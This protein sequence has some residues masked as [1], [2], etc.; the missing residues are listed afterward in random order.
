[1]STEQQAH[2]MPNTSFAFVQFVLTKTPC[3]VGTLLTYSRMLFNLKINES[4]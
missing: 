3:T 2:N 1:M 4:L